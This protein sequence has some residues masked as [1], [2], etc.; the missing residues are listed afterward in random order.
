MTVH[1]RAQSIVSRC[2]RGA[3]LR[4]GFL[5]Y[6]SGFGETVFYLEP[7]SKRVP[8]C[9]A[10]ERL[11]PRDRGLFGDDRDKAQTWTAPMQKRG[12]ANV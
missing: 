2:Q 12:D 3:Y 4:K 10:K 9:C 1:L 8:A 7:G 5:T 6:E 11:V